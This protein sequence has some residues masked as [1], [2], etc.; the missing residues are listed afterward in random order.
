MAGSLRPNQIAADNAVG[1][2]RLL[3]FVGASSPFTINSVRSRGVICITESGTSGK[4]SSNEFEPRVQGQLTSAC[5]QSRRMSRINHGRH[6][7]QISRVARPGSDK[8]RHVDRAVHEHSISEH[9]MFLRPHARQHRRMV[10]PGDGR[11]RDLH[12]SHCH[13]PLSRQLSNRRHRPADHRA[14]MPR[15][16]PCKRLP[17]AARS[18]RPMSHRDQRNDR[19]RHCENSQ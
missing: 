18:A 14:D 5:S 6:A 11:I 12:P 10:W 8:H 1:G 3:G 16:H 15:I 9:A 4:L 2:E 19:Q 13:A 7:D 17:H